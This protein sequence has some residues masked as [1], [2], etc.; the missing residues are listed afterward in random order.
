M[1]NLRCWMQ[2]IR[3]WATNFLIAQSDFGP[4][5]DCCSLLAFRKYN[6]NAWLTRNLTFVMLHRRSARAK[7]KKHLSPSRH[8][9]SSSLRSLETQHS[10]GIAAGTPSELS[11]CSY[12]GRKAPAE[13]RIPVYGHRDP[14]LR[15]L[16]TQQRSEE[17]R[18][19]GT[20]ILRSAQDDRIGAFLGIRA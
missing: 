3:E 6:T 16:E 8:E 17:S 9:D 1:Y 7:R 15:S 10:Q 18:S 19:M 13:R 11:S 14:S 20:E 12:S 4:F 5:P 2:T